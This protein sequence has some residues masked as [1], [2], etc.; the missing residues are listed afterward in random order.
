MKSINVPS[1]GVPW[2]F[3]PSVDSAHL[4]YN[5][6]KLQDKIMPPVL[7]Y[8]YI[9]SFFVVVVLS[10][11]IMHKHQVFEIFSQWEKVKVHLKTASSS[12]CF[13]SF[14][15]GKL[16]CLWW[17]SFQPHLLLFP[18]WVMMETIFSTLSKDND[19]LFCKWDNLQ[20]R[21]TYKMEQ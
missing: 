11:L 4:Y 10:E 19:R 15:S 18:Y 16:R 17:N 3:S 8:L 9:G 14:V 5:Q 21:E 12:H 20:T 13:T 1:L 7:L 2:C 6:I